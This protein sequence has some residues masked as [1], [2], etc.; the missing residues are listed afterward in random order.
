MFAVP[1]QLFS[2]VARDVDFLACLA[3]VQRLLGARSPFGGAAPGGLDAALAE[4]L[5][6]VRGPVRLAE[7]RVPSDVGGE[8][9]WRDNGSALKSTLH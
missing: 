3:L 5:D 6:V 2:V 7:V 9:A 4:G 1:H 8:A